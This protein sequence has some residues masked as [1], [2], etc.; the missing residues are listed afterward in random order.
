MASRKPSF[1][2]SDHAALQIGLGSEGDGMQADIKFAP[3]FFDLLEDRLQR[4]FG[5][6]IQRHKNR[7]FKFLGKGLDEFLSLLVAI[8]HGEV[9][10]ESAKSLSAAVSNRLVVGDAGDQCLLALEKRQG[11]NV[12]HACFSSSGVVACVRRTRRVWRAII[13]SSSVGMT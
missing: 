7:R 11:G 3:L 13:S 10:A 8:G 5:L 2:Q 1:E 9:G 12:D 4:A 6:E